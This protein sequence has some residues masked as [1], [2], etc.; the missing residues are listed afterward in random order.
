LIDGWCEGCRYSTFPYQAKL[1]LKKNNSVH[2]FTSMDDVW[3]VINL[4]KE[5]L[6]EHNK[7][8]NK[9]FELHQTIKSHIPFFTCQNHF[10]DRQYQRDIQRYIYCTKMKVSPFEGSYG[11]HPKKWIDKCNVIEKMLNY[12]QSKQLKVKENG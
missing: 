7:T 1:P 8:S 3:Y 9:K 11:N 6:E 4:L 12:I 5:E 2:T 10:L